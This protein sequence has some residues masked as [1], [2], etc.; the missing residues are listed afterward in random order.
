MVKGA[1]TVIS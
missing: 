1:I